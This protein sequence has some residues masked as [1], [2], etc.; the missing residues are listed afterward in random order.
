MFT[1]C[2]YEAVHA[3]ET[4]SA[5]VFA[6]T[7][8]TLWNRSHGLSASVHQ[9]ALC[10]W[11]AFT[12][13]KVFFWLPHRLPDVSLGRWLCGR[14]GPEPLA[15]SLQSL[16]PGFLA[17]LFTAT[18]QLEKAQDLHAAHLLFCLS[19]AFPRNGA[20]TQL[21][22]TFRPPENG[23]QNASRLHV[24]SQRRCPVRRWTKSTITFSWDVIGAS[25]G[26]NRWL[27]CEEPNV[28]ASFLPSF[29]PSFLQG[30]PYNQDSGSIYLLCF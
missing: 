19:A 4:A 23:Q 14:T 7:A 21:F 10:R 13:L 24:H 22:L 15:A 16:E 2:C 11:V 17:A 30:V 27:D 9:D 12:C 3:L 1:G 28:I 25:S 29:P 26:H 20:P 5:G 6:A 8:Q 18:V